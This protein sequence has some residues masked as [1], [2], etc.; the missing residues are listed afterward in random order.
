MAAE[1]LCALQLQKLADQSVIS[2]PASVN[3]GT[4]PA[5]KKL[6]EEAKAYQKKGDLDNC[7]RTAQKAQTMMN[8]TGGGSATQ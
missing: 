7:A 1:D 6:I 2:K 5:V 3:S 4:S 8:Q